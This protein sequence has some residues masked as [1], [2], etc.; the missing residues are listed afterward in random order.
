MA[1]ALFALLVL[2]Q[3]PLDGPVRTAPVVPAAR[4]AP[5]PAPVQSRPSAQPP[6]DD[7]GY[8][9]WCFGAVETYLSLYDRVMPEVTR[10]ERAFPSPRGAAEDLKV[11]PMVRDQARKDL[12]TFRE[13][14]I[15]TEKA[16]PRPIS[17][18]G[19]TAMRAG[20]AV[21]TGADRATPAQL[22]REW[23]GWTP[24]AKCEQT[25][26]ALSVKSTVLGQ[27]LVF[28]APSTPEPSAVPPAPEP[29][30][31]PAPPPAAP[32]PTPVRAPPASPP[33]PVARPVAAPKPAAPPKP[34]VA[35]AAPKPAAKT[36]QLRPLSGETRTASVAAK[37][38]AAVAPAPKPVALPKGAY[39]M[40]P[41][42]DKGCAGRIDAS[43][44][45]GALVMMC[46]P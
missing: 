17:T 41:D 2:A 3:A 5:A 35:A 28:N 27:A 46:M 18:Y 22:A 6:T 32:A 23:M 16:S 33:A 1:A 14:I 43:I 45:N 34:V 37:P 12:A 30:A 44:R 11:Y 38:A 20:R 31:A 26:K 13:A 10:I 39:V 21:W 19:A 42:S 40:D 9:A 7:Y 24:P 36:V 15:A 4:P 29:V 8:V 25:A